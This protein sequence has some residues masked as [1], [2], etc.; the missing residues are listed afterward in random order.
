MAVWCAGYLLFQLGYA[1]PF[2]YWANV[3]QDIGQAIPPN[4]LRHAIFGY[5]VTRDLN[6]WGGLG[7]FIWQTGYFSLCSWMVLVMLVSPQAGRRAVPNPVTPL[8]RSRGICAEA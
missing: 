1:L 4:A 6:T 7:F 2:M 3:G 5:T 8:A